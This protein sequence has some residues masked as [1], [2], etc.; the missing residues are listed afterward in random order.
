[1]T[2]YQQ[3][4]VR[5]AVKRAK[6]LARLSGCGLIVPFVLTETKPNGSVLLLVGVLD[7]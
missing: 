6:R 5:H 4:L 3:V 2:R 7:E 1:M